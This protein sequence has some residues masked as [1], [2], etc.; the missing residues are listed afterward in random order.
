MKRRIL[1]LLL[2]A[3]LLT[4]CNKDELGGEPNTPERT[5]DRIRFEIGFAPDGTPETKTITVPDFK[6][7]WE[8]G[9]AIGI[10]AV[11]QGR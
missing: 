3:M 8:V 9:D 10:F 5:D 4:G 7:T 6:T 1:F 2:P 11:K